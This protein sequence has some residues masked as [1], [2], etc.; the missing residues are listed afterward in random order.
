MVEKNV[1]DSGRRIWIDA[2][3]LQFASFA[4]LN[5]WLGERCGRNFAT[6][7]MRN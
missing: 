1:Q 2:Q 6:R 5:A 3:A 7:S 4:T